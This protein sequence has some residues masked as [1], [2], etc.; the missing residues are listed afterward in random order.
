M[1]EALF[2]LLDE[3]SVSPAADEIAARAGVSVSSLFR[4]FDGLDDLQEQTI[5]A[6]FARFGP[7]FDVPD[8]GVGPTPDRID[9]FVGARL[10]LYRTIAPV[11]RLARAR[12]LENDLIASKLTE[13]R[14][15]LADQVREH[16]DPEL[17]ALPPAR[18][19]D[20]GDLVDALTSFESWDLLQ[21]T[22][23]RAD[24]E[25]RRSWIAGIASLFAT[26]P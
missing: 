22:H 21:T 19:Q 4:Y 14:A 11:A 8:V 24:R 9:R 12:A 7:L 17:S 26:A 16:F 2:S 25:I 6:H 18:R 15:H 13:T 20:V 1:I 10:D 5:E 3:G 23:R